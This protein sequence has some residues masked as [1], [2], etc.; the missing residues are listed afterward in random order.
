MR[1][2]MP[3]TGNERSVKEGSVLISKTDAKGIIR[4]ANDDFV[5]ISGFS[6]EE[7]MGQPHNIVRHPDM[8]PA[9]FQDLWTTL[10]AGK[11]WTGLVKNRCK[12]GD[13]YWV[14]ATVRPNLEG[15]YTS[16][17]V[18]AD[19]ARTA[20][21]EDIYKRMRDGRC[22]RILRHG[23]LIRTSL[24][25]KVTELMRGTDIRLRLWL[26]I[27]VSAAL[28][29]A[30]LLVQ[31][32]GAGD[33]TAHMVGLS[34]AG[35]GIITALATGAWLHKDLI[36]PLQKAANQARELASGD[37]S[38]SIPSAG[39]NEVARLL[40]AL[41]AIRNNFQETL[42]YMR[43]G[44]E[45]LNDATLEL[46]GNA[47]RTS[48]AA[49]IQAESATDAASSMEEMSA[50]IDLVG[51]HARDADTLSQ[52]SGQRSE[53]G[54]RVIHEAAESMRAIAGLVQDSSNIIQE[55]EAASREISAVVTVIK[56]IADQ[57][58]LLA[59]NAAIEAARAGEQGRGFA[60]VADEV[61]KL[62]ERTGNSTQ[63][64]ATMVD[65]IQ[66]DARR[67]V[68]SMDAGVH[69]VSGGV[70]LAHQAGDSITT[71]RSSANQ[72]ARAVDDITMALGQQ[73]RA[74]QLIAGNIERI[75]QMSEE[76]SAAASSTAQSAKRLRDMATQLQSTV[77]QFKV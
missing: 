8:P 30:L 61:R 11:A 19:K 66:A 3:V 47:D 44:V 54:G 63:E 9:A 25:W 6:R 7:L 59:L 5:A 36:A 2:N 69:R 52:E 41:G 56:E 57:T 67:A 50:S 70:E 71:I 29:L 21:V 51:Q 42:Y 10:K 39:N 46:A 18:R 4:Y 73:G 55:L 75:A 35:L 31:W 58:N 43:V 77:T 65:K 1:T 34:L 17:R 24:Y 20:A 13:H 45:T 28:F 33:A 76:N 53:E 49:D 48:K 12:N 16:V 23:Q 72:V 38:R 37:L 26:A 64:I 68:A 40:E 62:A 74:A 15:G 14:E 22:N 32:T 27:T 60:V